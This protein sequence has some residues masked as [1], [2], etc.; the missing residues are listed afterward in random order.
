VMGEMAA[1]ECSIPQ[2][3]TSVASAALE[4]NARRE[5]ILDRICQPLPGAEYFDKYTRSTSWHVTQK[6]SHR[7]YD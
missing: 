5:R 3:G 6:I 7:G 1:S 4:R 2:R